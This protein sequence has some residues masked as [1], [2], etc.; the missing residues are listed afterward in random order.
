[1]SNLLAFL[2]GVIIILII[3]IVIALVSRK[4]ITVA[5]GYGPIFCNDVLGQ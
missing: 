4:S 3:L 5:K 2:L 1:M